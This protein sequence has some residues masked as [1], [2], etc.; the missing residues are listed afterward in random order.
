MD[1]QSG[2][3]AKATSPEPAVFQPVLRWNS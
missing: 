3:V 2:G 1:P